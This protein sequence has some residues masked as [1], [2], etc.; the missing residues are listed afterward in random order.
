MKKLIS[1]TL[2]IIMILSAF[3][4]IPTASAK[5]KEYKSKN[6]IYTLNSKGEATVVGN[7]YK[8]YSWKTPSYWK[9]PSKLD[10]H[11]V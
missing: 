10:G 2:T 1:I 8:G 3:T 11:K 5:A 9:I 7:Y 4:V 6:C